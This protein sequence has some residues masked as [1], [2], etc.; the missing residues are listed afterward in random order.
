MTDERTE[1]LLIASIE[2]W[3]SA[4]KGM[5]DSLNALRK[6]M[7]KRQVESAKD[8]FDCCTPGTIWTHKKSGNTYMLVGWGLLEAS[9]EPLV[10]Y[11]SLSDGNRWFRPLDEWKEKFELSEV[12]EEID[13]EL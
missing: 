2:G 10:H 1:Q 4:C 11:V 12:P 3:L 8:L 6:P 7:L 9:H 5:Q 13:H